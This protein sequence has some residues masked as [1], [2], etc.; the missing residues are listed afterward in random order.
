MLKQYREKLFA[1]RDE[2][3]EKYPDVPNTGLYHHIHEVE[4]AMEQ[5]ACMHDW[6]SE[7]HTSHTGTDYLFSECRKCRKTKIEEVKPIT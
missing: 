6:K 2:L 5:N 4:T 1:L 3:A 7:P